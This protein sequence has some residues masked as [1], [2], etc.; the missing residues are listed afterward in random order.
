MIQTEK[1][2]NPM[3]LPIACVKYNVMP[4]GFHRLDNPNP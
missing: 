1:D 3:L 4:F 2:Y